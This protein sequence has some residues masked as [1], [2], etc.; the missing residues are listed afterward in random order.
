MKVKTILMLMMALALS[1]CSATK[2]LPDGSVLQATT[3]NDSLDRSG[4]MFTV[5]KPV[6]RNEDGTVRYQILEKHLAVSSTV[7]GDTIKGL[8]PT[9]TGAFI[10]AQAARDVARIGRCNNANCGIINNVQSASQSQSHNQTDIGIG[11]SFGGGAPLCGGPSCAKL[12][13]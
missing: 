9:V 13:Q 7:A 10:Q 2:T 1:A 11:L 8:V 4:T 5:A 6:G 3:V 12:G